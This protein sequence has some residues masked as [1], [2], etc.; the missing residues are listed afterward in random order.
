MHITRYYLK[1]RI[2]ISSGTDGGRQVLNLIPKIT[3]SNTRITFMFLGYEIGWKYRLSDYEIARQN[4]LM[5]DYR[6]IE[7]DHMGRVAPEKI[8]EDDGTID[9]ML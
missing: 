9:K 8:L 6:A 4:P 2:T 1:G 7:I 3:L 5:I